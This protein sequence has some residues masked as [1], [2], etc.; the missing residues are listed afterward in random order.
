MSMG[1]IDRN[2]TAFEMNQKLRTSI[3]ILLDI[4]LPWALLMTLLTGLGLI[5]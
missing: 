5:F 2:R 4:C 3:Y 1:H